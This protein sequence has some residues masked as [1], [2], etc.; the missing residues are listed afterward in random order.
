MEERYLS[1]RE[2]AMR[3]SVTYQTI[4]SMVRSGELDSI[5]VRSSLR[6][7]ESALA[8][9]TPFRTTKPFGGGHE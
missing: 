5:R 3:L 7:P 6:I 1:I 4:W 2:V 9:L 8:K